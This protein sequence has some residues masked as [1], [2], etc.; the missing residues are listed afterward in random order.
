MAPADEQ[1]RVTE[2]VK[3][4]LDRRRREGESDSNVVEQLL[5]DDRELFAGFGM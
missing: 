3:S 5:S 4:E 1:V 2:A